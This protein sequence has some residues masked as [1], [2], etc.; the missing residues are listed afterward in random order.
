MTD[1]RVVRSRIGLRQALLTLM[2]AAPLE[3][4]T[5]RDIAAAAGVSYATYF[6]HYP[7]KETLLEDLA[8]DEVGR[9][10]DFTIP[11]SEAADAAAACAA[12]CDYVDQRRALWSALLTGAPG[13]VREEMLRRA[14]EAVATGP[15]IWLP[16][17][18]R[19]ILGVSAIIEVLT[20]WLRQ[21]APM[22]AAQVAQIL[23]RAIMSGLDAPRGAG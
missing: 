21:P 7:S 20:W 17:D 11:I 15:S 14:A 10:S 19:V 12:L 22:P 8:A 2:D 16:N 13:F 1:A 23:D 6:R 18:L 4:I 5:I 3:A 9:L